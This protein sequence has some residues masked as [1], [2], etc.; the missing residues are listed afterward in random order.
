LVLLTFIILISFLANARFIFET[1]INNEEATGN[2]ERNILS[3][4]EK[5]EDFILIEADENVSESIDFETI[6]NEY[7]LSIIESECKKMNISHTEKV[8]D[9]KTDN[10]GEDC[11]KKFRTVN[12]MPIEKG[13]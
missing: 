7:N 12:R 13:K 4:K 5:A 11:R 8:L 2:N 1:Q 3:E 6:S 9:K 10:K